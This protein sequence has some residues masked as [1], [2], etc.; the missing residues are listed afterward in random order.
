V[1]RTDNCLVTSHSTMLTVARISPTQCYSRQK[2]ERGYGLFVHRNGK[3]DTVVE[4]LL[5]I[6]M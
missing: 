5:K 6:F 1:T 4:T 2:T 3:L